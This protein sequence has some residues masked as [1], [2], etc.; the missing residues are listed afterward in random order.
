MLLC[1]FFVTVVPLLVLV[2]P[3][4]LPFAVIP[5]LLAIAFAALLCTPS[6]REWTTP[7]DPRGTAG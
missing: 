6:A 4:P 1:G 2:L 7:A 5:A 3:A